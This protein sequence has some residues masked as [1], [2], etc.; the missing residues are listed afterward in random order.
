MIDKSEIEIAYKNAIHFTK[1]HYENFP[2]LSV[3]VPKHLQK[4][5]AIVY[6]FARQADDIA[7][8]GTFTVRERIVKLAE[9]EKQLDDSLNGIYN[10]YFWLALAN[11]INNFQLTTSNFKNLL[12]AFRQ[13][14]TK[15]E[16][17]TFDE[18]LNYCKYS[19]NPVGRIILELNGIKNENAFNYSDSI[20]T[21]LQITN[22]LQ[23]VS[24]D[25]KKGRVYLPEADMANYNVDVN[26]F[27]TKIND[28]NFQ[29][30]I[31]NEIEIVQKYFDDGKKLLPYLPFGLKQQI[32]WTIRGGIGILAK[33]ENFKYDVLN[34]RPKYSKVDLIKLLLNIK[35]R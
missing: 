8:E 21:A 19:A 4:H 33:I 35:I 27:N 18:L 26:I 13:D 22:F 32:K 16:Y 9:Y 17:E 15:T 29:A 30:L 34:K 2:V 31:K 12:I 7:D 3:F 25:F 6:Q 20:C 23:D 28:S 24:I 11:T 10:N 5:V 14:L 1:S